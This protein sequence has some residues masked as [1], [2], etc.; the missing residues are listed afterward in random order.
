MPLEK[1]VAVAG[2][3]VRFLGLFSKDVGLGS[4]ERQ[5]L[6]ERFENGSVDF[7]CCF[8]GELD[9]ELATR[10]WRGLRAVLANDYSEAD[11]AV[12]I[13]P[14]TRRQYARI[15]DPLDPD[16]M[17][18]FG[19]YRNG[20]IEPADWYELTRGLSVEIQEPWNVV[21]RSFGEVQGIIHAFF[22]E[23][24]RPYLKV[25][26]LSTQQLVICYFKPELYSAAVEILADQD[27][28]VFVEGW[29]TE[30]P[31]TGFVVEIEATDFRLA[32]AFSLE[33]FWSSLGTIPEY[34]G[35]RSTQQALD[36]LR[37]G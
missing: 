24:D 14:A 25:R 5:W 26:E 20:G 23:A 35:D 36:S 33:G 31:D 1:L 16:E 3:T 32:P 18:R 30:S 21:P 7:D 12:L 19:L 37:N 8:A 9:E 4:V 2:A 13:R 15:A 34:T 22:K 10:G 29:T 11:M 27:A 28:V 6:A 17:I